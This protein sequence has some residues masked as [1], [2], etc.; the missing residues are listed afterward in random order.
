MKENLR[1]KF[2]DSEK[3]NYVTTP[4]RLAELKSAAGQTGFRVEVTERL[5][6]GRSPNFLVV[7]VFGREGVDRTVFW[8]KARQLRQ[9]PG[10]SKPQS[11]DEQNVK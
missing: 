7:K 4:R 5:T 8:E 2:V 9:F 10:T 11:G 1:D 6:V 3:Q